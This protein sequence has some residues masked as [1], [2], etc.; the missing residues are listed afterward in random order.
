MCCGDQLKPQDKVVIRF[1]HFADPASL[2][3]SSLYISALQITPPV[4]SFNLYP[5]LSEVRRVLAMQRNGKPGCKP[6][7]I[8]REDVEFAPDRLGGSQ[9]GLGL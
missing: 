4:R 8:R 2:R 5:L 3:A 7:P 6:T 1:L 9:W